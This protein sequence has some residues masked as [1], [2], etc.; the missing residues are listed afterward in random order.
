MLQSN[1]ISCKARALKQF[2][3]TQKIH[4]LSRVEWLFGGIPQSSIHFWQIVRTHSSAKFG[5]KTRDEFYLDVLRSFL[6]FG[7]TQFGCKCEEIS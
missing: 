5:E 4:L 3:N 7:F 2:S 6:E 1:L